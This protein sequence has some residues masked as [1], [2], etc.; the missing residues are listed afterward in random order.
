MQSDKSQPPSSM[1]SYKGT[2]YPEC[3]RFWK[4][5][6]IRCLVYSP[7][8]AQTAIFTL[9]LQRLGRDGANLLPAARHERDGERVLRVERDMLTPSQ[10]SRSWHER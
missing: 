2:N 5:K 9:L 7:L 6:D 8:W 4:D 3:R 10:E 1:E